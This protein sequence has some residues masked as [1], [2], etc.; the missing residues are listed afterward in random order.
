LV[1][2]FNFQSLGSVSLEKASFE[3]KSAFR[4]LT[5]T[6]VYSQFRSTD[7]V[8]SRRYF[9]SGFQAPCINFMYLLTYLSETVLMSAVITV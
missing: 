1:S 2:I 7:G 6:L 9:N 3:S 8:L 4:P 5:C